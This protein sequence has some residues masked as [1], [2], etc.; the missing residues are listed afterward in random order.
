MFLTSPPPLLIIRHI[1]S[2]SD[3]DVR[4]TAITTITTIH[5]LV[6]HNTSHSTGTSYLTSPNTP[7]LIKNIKAPT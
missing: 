4:T 5:Q 3:G 7:P 2:R 6:P 1:F